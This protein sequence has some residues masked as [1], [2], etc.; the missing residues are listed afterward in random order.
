M[1]RS[2]L[3]VG[4]L[5]TMALL[6]A[7][8]APAPTV[9]TP[10]KVIVTVEVPKEVVVTQVVEVEKV[11]EVPAEPVDKT[12]IEFWTTDNEEERVNAYEA[13]AQRFMAAH[14]EIDL[15]IVPIEEAGVSQR[16]STAVAANRLPD[17]IRMYSR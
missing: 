5:L 6:L 9:P 14:P 11:V 17:I 12:V 8:C 15:R 1:K 7:Q 3:A 2:S 10:E 16:I 4:L 13:V